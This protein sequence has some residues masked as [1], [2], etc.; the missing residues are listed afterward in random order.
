[1]A[2]KSRHLKVKKQECPV[3]R[4]L[5]VMGGKW[6]PL[7]LFLVENGVN[8]FGLIHRNMPS[9]SKH[10]LTKDLRELEKAKVIS[11]TV[12]AEVPPRVEY[13]LTERGRSLLPIIRAMKRW[14]E[15]EVPS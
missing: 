10:I 13:A 5:N 7:I 14:G 8:R 1:M 15:S 6:K 2:S 3:T 4:C 12:F 9:V 11:R